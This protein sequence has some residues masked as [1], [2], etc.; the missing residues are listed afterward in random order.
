MSTATKILLSLVAA[1]L[2][3]GDCA[4][5]PLE[6]R[7]NPFTRPPSAVTIPD[8]EERGQ[9]DSMTEPVV[10]ATL[11]ASQNTFA[12]VDGRILRPGDEIYGYTLVKVLENRAIFERQGNRITVYVKPQLEETNEK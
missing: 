10:L 8:R 12:N 7:H 11:V 3:H 5:E 1:L 6:L 9:Q 4:A 2:V